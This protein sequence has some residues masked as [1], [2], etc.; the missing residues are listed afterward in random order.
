MRS[1]TLASQKGRFTGGEFPIGASEIQVAPKPDFSEKASLSHGA[2]LAPPRLH[3][4]SLLFGWFGKSVFDHGE[5]ATIA[6]DCFGDHRL[7]VA[8]IPTMSG[9][10]SGE[11]FSDDC[12][13]FLNNGNLRLKIRPERLTLLLSQGDILIDS[14][15]G[16][17]LVEITFL[18]ISAASVKVEE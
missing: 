17:L 7:F 10:A 6:H 3:A 15:K 14:I 5:A 12:R 1:A 4:R 9:R 11:L 13:R 18:N 8:R 16:F 2:T